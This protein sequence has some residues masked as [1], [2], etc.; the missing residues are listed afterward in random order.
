MRVRPVVGDNGSTL[1]SLFSAMARL[2][3]G[4][5]PAQ[6]AAE[7]TS[8]GRSGPDPGLTAV[9]V[10]G[11][12]GPIDVAAV[13]VLEAMTADVRQPLVLFLIA[14]GLL[15]ATAT[16]NVASVQL[17]RSTTRRREIAIRAALGAGAGRLARQLLIENV[18]IGLVGGFV[19]LM[20]AV[21][22]HRA[23][24]ALL[25]ADFPRS[26]DVTL[27]A[28]VVV[29]SLLVSLVS[30]VV[31]GLVPALQARRVDLVPSLADDGLAPAGGSMRTATARLRALIMAGQVAVASVLLIGAS[32]LVRSFVA[33]LTADRGYDITNIL[34][35]RIPMPDASFTPARRTQVLD[36]I[37]ERVRAT[38]GVTA[39]AFTT[40][41]PLGTLDQ[42]LAFTMPPS[43][44]A[45]DPIQVQAAMRI[46]SPSY[47]GAI[48]MRLAEG[49]GLADSDTG[50][51]LPV[52]LVN[53]AFARRYFDN[54]ALGRSLPAGLDHARGNQ[55]WEV[56]G[57]LEDVRMKSVT[58]PPQPEIFV[59]N[60][61]VTAGLSSDPS[62]VVRTT[63]DVEAFV[64]RLRELVR[65]QDGS[66]A[67]DAVVT[68]EQR[69]AGN[70]AR[71]RLYA[72]LL[73][74]F[75]V[76]AVT[77]AAVGLFGVL[78]YSVSQRSREIA[79]R[80]ALGARPSRIIRLV[81]TQGLLVTCP[82]LAAGLVTSFLLGRSISTFLYGVSPHDPLTF[83]AVPI[84]LGLIA[85]LA[86]FVPAR[87]AARVDPVTVLR[88]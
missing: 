40:V 77:I 17:A 45:T 71:P 50:T 85:A 57:V 6:A 56:V 8:R 41:L 42:L 15:L 39:A 4:V 29:F 31:F 75:A 52:V 22:L 78:S 37:L 60:A 14:V 26:A 25:P 36:A 88:L 16:A 10:F 13:P 54:Q 81:V 46:V 33:M 20:A 86:C 58:D 73:G 44:T 5:T 23:L 38:E 21:L 49:R 84:V 2:K 68:M 55:R 80:S 35:A 43:G 27:D 62:L 64:P 11:S 18:L 69:L 47:V 59:S 30:A 24:P 76:C 34:T 79:V 9:A 65:Q 83:A 12:R 74:A 48:G 72:V 19:G 61:Q 82:G 1:I 32:L 63:G 67:L 66:L 70:L 7:A 28:R 87:R 51:S 53:R 3:P